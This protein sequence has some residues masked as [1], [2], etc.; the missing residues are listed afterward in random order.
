M[1]IKYFKEVLFMKVVIKSQ[2]EVQNVGDAYVVNNP[3]FLYSDNLVV[4]G[5]SGT[6]VACGT[7]NSETNTFEL[8]DVERPAYFVGDD[9]EFSYEKLM[10]LADAEDLGNYA[11]E[12]EFTIE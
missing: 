9:K 3:N 5:E 11:S 1:K 12:V 7:Y 6:Y 8:A 2:N 10:D 4:K